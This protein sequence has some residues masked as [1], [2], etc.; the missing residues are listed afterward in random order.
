MMISMCSLI[1]FVSVLLSIFALMF[2]REIGLKSSFFVQSLSDL[3]NKESVAS[4][5]EFASAP[6]GSSLLN[7]LKSIGRISLISDRILH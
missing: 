6:S 1:W 7:S 5:N 2:I 4:Q 3:N